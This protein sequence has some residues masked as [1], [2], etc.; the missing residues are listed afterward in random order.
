MTNSQTPGQSDPRAAP[1]YAVVW[2][3]EQ[4]VGA[5]PTSAAVEGLAQA[6]GLIQDD[7]SGKALS[8]TIT[9]VGDGARVDRFLAGLSLRGAAVLRSQ[10]FRAPQEAPRSVLIHVGAAPAGLLCDL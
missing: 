5:T 9:L 8:A 10:S 7:A 4:P 2:I 1:L 3:G 6:I